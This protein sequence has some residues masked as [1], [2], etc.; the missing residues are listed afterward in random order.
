MLYEY[1]FKDL[2]VNPEDPSLERL[3]GKE[4]YYSNVPLYCIQWANGNYKIGTLK[5]IRK[6]CSSPFFVE[7]P[8]GCVSSY[9]CIVPKKEEPKPKPTYIPFKNIQEFLLSYS[10]YERLLTEDNCFLSNHGIWLKEKDADDALFM[11]TKIW[12]YGVCV[13]GN[14]KTTE[15]SEDFYITINEAT[16]WEQLLK[17]YTFLDGTPCGVRTR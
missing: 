15:E 17:R 4:V 9:I 12:S 11:V 3:I 16:T 7:A 13:S 2:I 6:D 8:G 14:T 10:S 1:T 5:E